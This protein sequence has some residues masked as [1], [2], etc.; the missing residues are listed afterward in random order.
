M[1]RFVPG[2][3]VFTVESEM[4]WRRTTRLTIIVRRGGAVVATASALVGV[5]DSL[6]HREVRDMCGDERGIL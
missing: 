5:G 4:L 6:A 2:V 1:P 3:L